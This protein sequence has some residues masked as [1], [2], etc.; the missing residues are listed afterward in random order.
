MSFNRILKNSFI[1]LFL[2]IPFYLFGQYS[3]FDDLVQKTEDWFKK[4]PDSYPHWLTPDEAS[5]ENTNSREFYETDPPEGPIFNIT[6]F[7]P[8]EGVLIRYPFGISYTVIAE[9]AEDIMVTTIVSSAGQQN[10][11]TNQ[12]NSNDVNL[13]NCNFLIAPSNSYWTRDYGPWYI[14]DGDQD[15]AIINFPYNR[16][17]PLDNDIPIEMAD[18]LGLDLYG[19]NVITAGGNYMTDGMGISA[20]SSL[21]FEENPSQTQYQIRNKIENYLGVPE[22]HVIDDPNNTYIDHIDCWAKYLDV[23][24]IIIR[25]V[26][27]SHAQYDEIEEV[28]D[29]FETQTTGYNTPY[30]IYRV[31]TPQNQPY[32]NSIILNDKVLVPQTG[33]SW[34]DDAIDVYEEAMPGYEIVGV[35]GSWESTDAIHCRAKGIADREMVFISHTPIHG[36]IEPT[37]GEG[38]EIEATLIPLDD[39]NI[40][41]LIAEIRFKYDNGIYQT[42]SLNWNNENNFSGFIPQCSGNCEVSY[43]IQS[44]SGSGNLYYHPY[45]GEPDPHIFN[46][47]N[48]EVQ[49]PVAYSENWNLVGNPVNTTENQVN[50]L[51]PSST[52]NTLYSFGQ[53]GYVSQSEL[54]PGTGYWLHFQNDGMTAI[55]GLPI[56]EQTLNLFEGWNLISG[57]STEIPTWQIYDP[58]SILI[59][60][61]FYGYEPGSGY[62]NSDEIIPGNGYWVR[63]NSEG[64]I[65]LNGI[66]GGKV[67][68]FQN[69]TSGTDWI[70]I[71]GV[72]LFLGVSIPVDEQ[73]S[74]SL[75]PIPFETGNDVRFSGDVVYCEN[76]GI[77]EVQ[78]YNEFLNFEYNISNSENVWKLTDLSTGF[79]TTVEGNGQLLI[80]SSNQFHI[81]KRAVLPEEITLHPNFPNPF[82]PTTLISF[83]LS[84]EKFISLD[85][86]DLSGQFVNNLEKGINHA[87]YHSVEWNGK[88]SAGN[89][90]PAGIYF[91]TLSFENRKI[92]HKMILLK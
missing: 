70:S 74:Y 56:Y 8:M 53:N 73:P 27:Q 43:Y 4:H 15:L 38:I 24:K 32:S 14:I 25:S 60:N 33:S 80:R 6:E 46:M 66:F 51:F 1:L 17:R 31:Y 28:V 61:T 50:N 63:T 36:E 13:N 67:F 26:P 12:Y 91:Y 23:D 2:T 35:T 5:S 37:G 92:S 11:V 59:P 10:Y 47:I 42:I 41:D 85:I 45:I 86:Y 81:E 16:P 78:T 90:L 20:S 84:K 18:F 75:P 54:E 88:D 69:R 83:E 87:G 72:K 30:E 52:E 82:N 29:Y 71:N 79:N 34:D 3:Q 22:Y 21:V 39:E 7:A 40:S 9:M 57:L 68:E 89:S 65:E 64:L 19:M 44:V 58:S 77:I 76:E 55:G 62:V 49:I 48:P